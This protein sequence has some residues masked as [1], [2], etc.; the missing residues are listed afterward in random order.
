MD[1]RIISGI[2]VLE[3]V[4]SFDLE[5]VDDIVCSFDSFEEVQATLNDLNVAAGIFGLSFALSKCKAM[6]TDWTG[7]ITPLTLSDEELYF[8]VSFTYL[9]SCINASGIIADQ[10]T[11]R[12]SRANTC[13]RPPSTAGFR[14]QMSKDHWTYLSEAE[15]NQR[16]SAS[17]DFQID[18]QSKKLGG[19]QA[20]LRWL[21]HILRMDEE[22]L[23]QKVMF[24][25][26][27]SSRKKP[28]GG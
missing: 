23:A 1:Q 2:N 13:R 9:G 14:S 22:R 4:N 8:V 20:R 26:R 25:T 21:G 19:Y 17:K 6:L 10:I 7:S 3:T 18:W 15:D 24:A 12:I 28:C 11:S 5:Y 27:G 16:G